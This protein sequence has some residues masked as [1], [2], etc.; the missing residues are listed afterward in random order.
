MGTSVKYSL[1]IAVPD[2]HC[3]ELEQMIQE[4]ADYERMPNGPQLKAPQLKSDLQNGYCHAMVVVLTEAYEKWPKQAMVGYLIYY[5]AYSTW[6]GRYLFIE[7]IYVKPEFRR[8]GIGSALWNAAAKIADEQK[9][10]RIEWNVLA[11]NESAIQF[12]SRMGAVDL[13]KLESWVRFRLDR[14]HIESLARN[15]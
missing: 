10:P 4:L 1:Q 3:N 13:Y 15:V 14:A 11:W 12:Y 7:D 5:Y 9:L 6:E 2:I 8:A